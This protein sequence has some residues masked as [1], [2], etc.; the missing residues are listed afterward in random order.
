VK[1]DGG[2]ELSGDG[3]ANKLELERHHRV[4]A[5]QIAVPSAVVEPK[6]HRRLRRDDTRICLSDAHIID[7]GK[8][9]NV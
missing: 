6:A 3:A 4:V 7:G 8:I 5:A 2:L 9:L 1:A